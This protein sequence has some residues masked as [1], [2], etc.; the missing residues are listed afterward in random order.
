MHVGLEHRLPA[1]SRSLIL[2][3]ALHLWKLVCVGFFVFVSFL[4]RLLW[5]RQAEKT[6]TGTVSHLV[7][8]YV[9]VS[10]GRPL[11]VCGSSRVR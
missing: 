8:F 4:Y 9:R 5:L 1:A 11:C 3:L 6:R 10:N 7:L 2:P